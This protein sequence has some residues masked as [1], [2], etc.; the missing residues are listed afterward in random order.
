MFVYICQI[1]LAFSLAILYTYICPLNL[2]PIKHTIVHQVRARVCSFPAS[3]Y[4]E[5]EIKK[6]K[7]K[8][9]YLHTENMV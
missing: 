3:F 4:Y 2:P 9:N 6:K 1:T 5:N 7:T 8:R